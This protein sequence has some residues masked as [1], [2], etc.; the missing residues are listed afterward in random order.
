MHD[1][2]FAMVFKWGQ[3]RI[4]TKRKSTRGKKKKKNR[5][6]KKKRQRFFLFVSFA[7]WNRKRRI[8][9]STSQFA[10]VGGFSWPFV[11]KCEARR[12]IV[13]LCSPFSAPRR[14]GPWPGA[15][16]LLLPTLMERL[17]TTTTKTKRSKK[18]ASCCGRELR[19]AACWR[20]RGALLG[21]RGLPIE[22]ERLRPRM[23]RR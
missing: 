22:R 14:R 15:A 20:W 6:S 8:R 4:A 23:K 2:I 12:T 10:F 3:S 21:S 19:A 9:L 1:V 18:E 11:S 16:L 13:I 7:A 5:S 17:T